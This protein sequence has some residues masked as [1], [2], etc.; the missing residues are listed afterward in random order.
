MGMG[1][2]GG[3]GCPLYRDFLPWAVQKRWSRSIYCLGCGLGEPKDA[4]VQS[5][6]PGGANVPSWEGT[7][8]PPSEYDWTVRLRQRCGFM[9][10]YFDHLLI[11]NTKTRH[12]AIT[13]TRWHFAFAQCCHSN[14][15][16][17]PIANPPN[18]AQLGA[19]LTILKL[20]LGPCSS[21]RMRRRTDR[22]TDR[23]RQTRTAHDHHITSHWNK[24]L[25][26]YLLTYLH[27]SESADAG[28]D[29]LCIR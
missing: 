12:K 22:Q 28:L 29:G 2:F 23:H 5:Y 10:N 17:A 21:V 8:A 9:L 14:E 13:S 3:K 26:T 18:S 19:P 11:I 27:H 24:R 7:F 20:H 25:L 4:Q 16:R 6:S 15:T 1:N